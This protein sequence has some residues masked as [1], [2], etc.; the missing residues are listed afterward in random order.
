MKIRRFN[1]SLDDDI[2]YN[3]T[4]THNFTI[5][6]ADFLDIVN[7]AFNKEWIDEHSKEDVLYEYLIKRLTLFEH[8]VNYIAVDKDGNLIDEELYDNSKK[9]NI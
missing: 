3:G 7:R 9:F 8:K 4:I 2:Y 6:R 5:K 1:E